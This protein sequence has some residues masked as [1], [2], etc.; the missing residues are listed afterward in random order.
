TMDAS[1]I[2]K[3]ALSSG[4]IR[5]MGSTTF[6]DF[7]HLERDRALA[8]RIQKVEVKEP[9][10]EDTIKILQGLRAQYEEH[11]DVKYDNDA[12]VAAVRLSSQHIVDRFLPDKAIDVID[13]AGSRDRL[14]G[15]KRTRT[16]SQRD[17]ETVVARIA[18]VPVESLNTRE[19][20]SLK[21]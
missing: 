18:R 19:R 2:L 17:I 8:R 12:L 21:D 6:T 14:L 9:S 10:E 1:N 4:R 13:E 7:K 3:P 11:H 5:C 20:E 15:E 16:I